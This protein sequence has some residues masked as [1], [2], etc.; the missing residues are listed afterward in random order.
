MDIRQLGFYAQEVN[1]A[2]GEEAA[3]TPANKDTPWGITDRSMIAMLTKAVQE[4]QVQIQE[5]KNKLS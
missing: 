3:N 5:L 1:E 4:Q 2:L